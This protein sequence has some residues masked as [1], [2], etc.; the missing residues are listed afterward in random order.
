MPGKVNPSIAEMVNMVCYQVM[1]NNHTVAL[2]SQAGELELN[3]MMP[4]IAQNLLFAMQIMTNATRIFAERCIVGIVANEER[5]RE[6]LERNPA[7]A[8]ALAPRLG[9]AEAAKLAKEAVERNMTVRELVTEK[10]IL[11][12][13]ELDGVLD[14]RKMTEPGLPGPSTEG[15]QERQ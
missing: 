2:A 4:I 7:I 9:Y 6:L 1:G 8:T 15:G 10:G 12:E 13:E 11:S 3:V 5:C 14:L